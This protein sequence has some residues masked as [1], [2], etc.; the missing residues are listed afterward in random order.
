MDVV[1]SE[2][3]LKH[4]RPIV[5]PQMVKQGKQLTKFNSGTYQLRVADFVKRA[6]I[7]LRISKTAKMPANVQEKV[8]FLD[9]DDIKALKDDGHNIAIPARLFKTHGYGIENQPFLP[10]DVDIW[11]ELMKTVDWKK[12]D[13]SNFLACLRVIY[14]SD[15]TEDDLIRMFEAHD[16]AL[17]GRPMKLFQVD[18]SA[19][20]SALLEGRKKMESDGEASSSSYDS[21]DSDSS[22]L[23]Y[24]P[25]KDLY[26]CVLCSMTNQPAKHAPFCKGCHTLHNNKWIWMCEN[27]QCG[28]IM[29]YDCSTG[30]PCCP[31][32]GLM[33][34]MFDKYVHVLTETQD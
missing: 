7:F 3:I 25:Q 4:Y 15:I 28:V 34:P 6:E 13:C 18:D 29:K 2:I 26:Y 5:E 9:A 23:L 11:N 32:C 8:R 31:R 1:I 30:I 27:P 19:H 20:R 21:D 24:G 10:Q 14:N 12:I 33:R 22:P 16:D 17:L